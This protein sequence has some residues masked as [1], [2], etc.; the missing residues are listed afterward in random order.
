MLFAYFSALHMQW[1]FSFCALDALCCSRRGSAVGFMLTTPLDMLHQ[2][3][4][5]MHG[6][7]RSFV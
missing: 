4:L 3:L 5:R 7:K 2:H 1:R 6:P